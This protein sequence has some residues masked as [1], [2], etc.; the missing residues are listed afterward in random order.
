MSLWSFVTDFDEALL[1]RWEPP[2]IREPEADDDEA[3][4]PVDRPVEETVLILI[5]KEQRNG[6][7]AE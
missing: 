1:A 5:E 3:E 6:L 7:P 2:A 4:Y